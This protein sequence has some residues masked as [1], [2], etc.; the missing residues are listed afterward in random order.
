MSEIRLQDDL[1]TWL[2]TANLTNETCDILFWNIL[3]REEVKEASPP[4]SSSQYRLK[5]VPNIIWKD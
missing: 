1:W 3:C 2:M 4:S 5:C